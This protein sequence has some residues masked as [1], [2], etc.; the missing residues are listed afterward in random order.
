MISLPSPPNEGIERRI[1]WYFAT[2]RQN[3]NFEAKLEL[4]FM[5]EIVR[6]LKQ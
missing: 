5:K 2:Y 3:R 4:F 6:R 1:S